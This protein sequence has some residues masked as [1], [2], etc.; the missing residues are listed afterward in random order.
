MSLRL[1]INLIVG[2]L[3][4]MFVAG[5]LALQIENMRAS[6]SEEVVAAN[7]VASQLLRRLAGLNVSE[8]TPAML[9]FLKGLGRVRSTEI[10]LADA[11]GR[12]LYESPPS[13]YKAGRDAPAWFQ[14]MISPVPSSQTYDFADGRLRVR[15][16]ASRAALDAWDSILPFSAAAIILLLAIN[17]LV[18]WLVGRALRP[19]QQIVDGLV[20]LQAGRFDV[21]LP[22]LPGTEAAAIGAA[23]NRLAAALRELIESE[24]RAIGA[25]QQLSDSRELT[26]WID[27]RLEQERH[28]IARELHDELGQSVTAIRSLALSVVQR[29]RGQDGESCQ[30][31]QVIADESSRLYDAMHGLIP[32]LAPLV[33][34]SFGLGDALTDLAERTRKAHPEVQLAL[35]LEPGELPPLDPADALALY[36][37]AQEGITNALRHG[38]ARRL[39]LELQLEAQGLV[40]TLEDDGQGLAPDWEQ[41][42]GHHGLRWLAERVQGQAGRLSVQNLTPRGVRLR[43]ELPLA[44]PATTTEAV[45]G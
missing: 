7:R 10:S 42:P 29:T 16:N 13:L 3:T 41:R 26:R 4:V 23:F 34:D 40:L 45:A 19:L 22:P 25:E 38:E 12:T 36:R 28:L 44:T 20:Q 31:A 14:Q 6:V 24:R 33:L 18:F 2:M 21:A 30:A 15:A 9:Y 11:Q 1:K 8:G 17:C 39:T 32:R 37:A 27:H 35:R 43:V 5:L